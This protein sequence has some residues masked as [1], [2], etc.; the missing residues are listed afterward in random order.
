MISTQLAFNGTDVVMFL[1]WF[2]PIMDYFETTSMREF[3]A[4]SKLFCIYK[5]S[6]LFF[7]GSSS[8]D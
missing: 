3:L 4:A 5:V 1:V 8:M 2:P 7:V 6:W